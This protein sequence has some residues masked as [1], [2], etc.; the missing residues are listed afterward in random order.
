MSGK[1]PSVFKMFLRIFV[2]VL[3]F[4]LVLEFAARFYLFGFDSLDYFKMKSMHRL[5]RSGLIQLSPYPEILYELKPNLDT[6]LQGKKFKTNSRG[7]RDREY[8][9][10]KPDGVFRVAVVGDSVTMGWGV[11]IE[12]VFHS[13]LENRLNRESSKVRYE[14]INFGGASYGAD[15]CMAT[16]KYK[17]LEYQPDLILFSDVQRLLNP[18]VRNHFELKQP[19]D[20]FFES[21]FV[22]LLQNSRLDRN[23][24]V[25]R[26]RN[27]RAGRFVKRI[28][29]GKKVLSYVRDTGKLENI[30]AKLGDISTG[31]KI[32]VCIVRVNFHQKPEINK[33][34]AGKNGLFFVDCVAGFQKRGIPRSVLNGLDEHPDRRMHKIFADILYDDLKKDHLL[35]PIHR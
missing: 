35:E 9:L 18:R 2:W 20:G 10:R 30:Y 28:F 16:L 3:Y 22:K 5:E 27:S 24:L 31:R 14:F 34:L 29:P 7:L 13:V 12:E 19:V 26:V 21:Y 1:S 32:P 6:I 4:L 11:D 15:Q 33:I 23:F 25:D 17:A 8:S